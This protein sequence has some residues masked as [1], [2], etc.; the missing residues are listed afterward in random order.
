MA[1][2]IAIGLTTYLRCSNHLIPETPN[3]FIW[4]WTSDHNFST[5]SA[6]RAFFIGQTE[7]QGAKLL[8]KACAP[9]KCKF[10]MWLVL[11]DR[12]WKAPWPAGGCHLHPLRSRSRVY[13]SFI[14]PMCFC[15]GSLAPGIVA[16]W[17]AHIIPF[18]N[19]YDLAS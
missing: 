6:Y 3:R 5:V 17:P 1:C 16:P 11:H 14:D 8:M 4:K 15:Q 7:I 2:L 12:C 13:P 19:C 18:S 10:F 9:N